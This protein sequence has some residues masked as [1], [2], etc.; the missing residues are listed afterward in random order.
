MVKAESQGQHYDRVLNQSGMGFPILGWFI[1]GLSL[2]AGSS[3]H[4]ARNPS[5]LSKG[6]GPLHPS[7]KRKRQ[8]DTA[9]Q[10]GPGKLHSVA[11]GLFAEMCVGSQGKRFAICCSFQDTRHLRYTQQRCSRI[12]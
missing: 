3:A 12:A 5:T 6:N 8:E 7:S 9:G 1:S 10:D 2:S 11:A 4:E